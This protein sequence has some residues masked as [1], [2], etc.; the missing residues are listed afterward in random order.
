[1]DSECVSNEWGLCG[2]GGTHLRRRDRQ[3]PGPDP[4]PPSQYETISPNMRRI[5]QK[6]L[7]LVEKD[8]RLVEKDLRLVEEHR[9]NMRRLVPIWDYL[10]GPSCQCRRSLTNVNK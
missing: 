2:D 1:M 4:P 6:D 5:K 3:S 7:R 10:P 8:L 9:P